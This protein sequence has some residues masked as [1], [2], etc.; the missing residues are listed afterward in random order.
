MNALK[1]FSLIVILSFILLLFILGSIREDLETG[2]VRRSGKV[3]R[4]LR[5]E[6][7]LYLQG[8]SIMAPGTIIPLEHVHRRRN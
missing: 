7:G 6:Q 4:N 2:K 3:C 5:A 8:E 1:D